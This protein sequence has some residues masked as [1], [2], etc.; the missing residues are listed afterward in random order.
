MQSFNDSSLIVESESFFIRKCS[1][2]EK[3]MDISEG[4]ILYNSK[5]YHKLC[6]SAIESEPQSDLEKILAMLD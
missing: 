3:T 6:W 5:W 2:C 4:D 1:F